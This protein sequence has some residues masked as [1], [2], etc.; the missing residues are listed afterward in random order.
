MSDILPTLTY[1]TTPE[2]VDLPQTQVVIDSGEGDPN[3][4]QD[5]PI[6]SMY[7]DTLRQLLYLKVA[8]GVNGWRPIGIE[9]RT[10]DPTSPVTGQIWLRT[11]L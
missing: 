3:G 9:P 2:S 11:D 6:R 1:A 10:S 7:I 5:G 8:A 4:S